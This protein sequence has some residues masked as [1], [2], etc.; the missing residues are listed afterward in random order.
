[1][2]FAQIGTADWRKQRPVKR[3]VLDYFPDAVLEVAFCSWVGNEQH[4]PGTE[5]HW[6][7]A[8]SGDEL[9]AMI[10]H[11]LEA[12]TFDSDGVRHSA[13]VAWRALANLQK[14]LEREK[15]ELNEED[16][17][18]KSALEFEENEAWSWGPDK[19]LHEEEL[20]RRMNIIGQNGNDGEHYHVDYITDTDGKGAVN[21]T[22]SYPGDI[23]ITFDEPK[24]E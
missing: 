9:D 19:K 24:S 7:R 8:K 22:M 13:K 15:Q 3:G 1:M 4:N 21:Y 23:K 18:A 12:G 5:L 20:E 10:R 2:K 6:D 11:S 17:I 14:E 16:M